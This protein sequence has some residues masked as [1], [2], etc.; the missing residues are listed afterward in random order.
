MIFVASPELQAISPEYLMAEMIHK[1][2]QDT[3]LPVLTSECLCEVRRTDRFIVEPCVMKGR[4]PF[5][6][7]VVPV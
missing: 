7:R 5:L 1:D 3:S 2:S 6:H 4:G